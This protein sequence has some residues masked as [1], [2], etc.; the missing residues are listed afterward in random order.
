ME[1]M[2]YHRSQVPLDDDDKKWIL[3][4]YK[5]GQ[6][7]WTSQDGRK[8]TVEKL[9]DNHLRNTI[10]YLTR[11]NHGTSV[12]NLWIEILEEEWRRRQGFPA[13]IELDE[14]EGFINI[15]EFGYEDR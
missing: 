15:P 12:G 8:T 14:L 2:A 6:L 13:W 5:W 10:A 1:R 9:N 3:R 7:Y 4:C 11:T